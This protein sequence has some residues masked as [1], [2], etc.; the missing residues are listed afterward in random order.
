MN[1]TIIAILLSVSLFGCNLFQVDKDPE[2]QVNVM[3]RQLDV[4]GYELD[5]RDSSIVFK[6]K[7]NAALEGVPLGGEMLLCTKKYKT[8]GN[9]YF[10]HPKD[11]W[12]FDKDR[13]IRIPLTKGVTYKKESDA[14]SDAT[15]SM[16]AKDAFLEGDSID[17]ITLRIWSSKVMVLD[18]LTCKHPAQ[19]DLGGARWRNGHQMPDRAAAICVVLFK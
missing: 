16:I 6:I 5:L 15:V 9:I 17:Y 13:K 8:T 10:Y 7:E 1:K 12:K 14:V 19:T 2:Y 11:I 18:S 4:E 3:A